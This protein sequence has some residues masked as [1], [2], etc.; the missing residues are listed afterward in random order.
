[1]PRADDRLPLAQVQR[2]RAEALAGDR[3]VRLAA[4]AGQQPGDDDAED[5]DGQQADRQ[6]ARG[7]QVLRVAAEDEVDPA[8]EDVDALLQ[9]QERRHLEDSR[10]VIRMTSTAESSAGRTSGRVTRR[11]ACRRVAP[12]I[13]ADSSSEGSIDRNAA[14]MSR[15]TIG[16]ECRPSTQ[17]IPQMLKMLNGRAPKSGV[18]GRVDQPDLRGRQEDPGDRVE[19]AGHDQRHDRRGEEQRLERH[20]RPDVEVGQRRADGQDRTA[21]PPAKASELPQSSPIRPAP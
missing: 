8:G 15:K 6:G 18:G 4:A 20:R 10:L 19:D 11:R 7:L 5:G 9:T 16:E 13:S 12:D 17:I 1:M 2:P 21:A 3:L 14:T